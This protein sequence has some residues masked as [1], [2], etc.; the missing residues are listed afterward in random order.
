LTGVILA[1]GKSTRI[2]INKAF[3]KINGQ[4]IIDRTIDIFRDVFDDIILVTF[5]D[6]ILVTNN[7]IEYLHLDLKIVTDLIPNKGAL[8]GIYTGLFY[9][10]SQHIFVTACDMPF[11]NKGFI[12]YA[13]SKIDNFDVVV[14]RSDD[15]LQ[16]LHAIYSKRCRNHI[17]ASMQSNRLKIKSFFPKVRVK[18]ISSEEIHYFDPQQSLFFNI[19]HLDDLEKAKKDFN[20]IY[21][22]LK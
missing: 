13:I 3:L 18:E 14:P 5:D 7:P 21:I 15:G 4:R 11:I 2:G 16:P 12:E 10:S 22:S 17:E 9:A 6:I 8:G 20:D 19:N 1:G